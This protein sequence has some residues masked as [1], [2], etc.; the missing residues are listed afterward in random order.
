MP[1]NSI[2]HQI[3]QWIQ[4]ILNPLDLGGKKSKHVLIPIPTTNP[5]KK[6][7]SGPL[8]QKRK[9]I[10]GSTLR[11]FHISRSIDHMKL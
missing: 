6:T 7:K 11:F 10:V 9:G 2:D 3:R 4:Q 5:P 8:S 1:L